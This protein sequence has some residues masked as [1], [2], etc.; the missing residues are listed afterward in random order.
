MQ[1]SCGTRSSTYFPSSSKSWYSSVNLVQMVRAIVTGNRQREEEY[2]AG[3]RS[4]SPLVPPADRK[5]STWMIIF[6]WASA[7]LLVSSSQMRRS[8]SEDQI[9]EPGVRSPTGGR[10]AFTSDGSMGS[11][12]CALTLPSLS[13]TCLHTPPRPLLPSLP[14]PRLPKHHAPVEFSYSY[15][16]NLHGNN[17]KVKLITDSVTHKHN[18]R[19][20]SQS[21]SVQHAKHILPNAQKSKEWLKCAN[22]HWETQVLISTNCLLLLN[23]NNDDNNNFFIF[24]EITLSF[25]RY[26]F[27]KLITI[28]S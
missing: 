5:E 9:C 24:I 2:D 28:M 4:Q 12:L 20:V 26:P 17:N 6:F 27:I 16:I 14:R 7:S 3:K 25:L 13:W 21:C 19:D 8:V 23:K 15:L 11:S 1:W 10:S 18:W 22:V